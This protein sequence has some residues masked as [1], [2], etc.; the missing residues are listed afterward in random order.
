MV[1]DPTTSIANSSDPGKS[2]D[3]FRSAFGFD[4]SSESRWLEIA[5]AAMNDTPSLGR[6]GRY[7]LLA[8]AGRGGQGIVY[9]ARQPGTNRTIAIKRL[10]AGVH[11]SDAS[12]ARFHRE[13]SLVASLDHPGIV[14]VLGM[15]EVP[16]EL[17]SHELLLMEWVDGAAIDQWADALP[18]DRWQDILP[19]FVQVCDAIAFAHQRGVMHRDLKPSNILVD[20]TGRARVLDFGLAR[21]TGPSLTISRTTGF[22]GTPAYAS[23]EAIGVSAS[24]LTGDAARTGA[25]ALQG[26]DTRSDIFSLGAVLYRL[27]TRREPFDSNRG[28]GPLFDAIRSTDPVSPRSIVADLPRELEAI[29]LKALRK[30]PSERYQS[31][32]AFATDLRRFLA[33]ET[34]VAIPPSFGYQLR[35]VVRRHRAASMIAC[36]GLVGVL[37]FAGTATW[38]AIKLGK[39]RNALAAAQVQIKEKTTQ[40]EAALRDALVKSQQQQSTSAFLTSVLGEVD[41]LREHD[42]AVT[43]KELLDR[44]AQRLYAG[45]LADQPAEEIRLLLTIAEAMRGIAQ[46]NS[47]IKLADEALARAVRHFG[48]RS[49]L[50]AKAHHH[51]GILHES[52][53]N[54]I[55]SLSHYFTCEELYREIYGPNSPNT[56]TAIHNVGVGLRGAGYARDSL[57]YYCT[58]WEHRSAIFGELSDESI[59]SERGVSIAYRS[60]S[61]QATYKALTMDALVRAKQQNSFHRIFL[62]HNLADTFDQNTESDQVL[63]LRQWS[64]D[65]CRA[66]N[67]V[68]SDQLMRSLQVV[69]RSHLARQQP[70]LA[71]PLLLECVQTSESVFGH[72]HWNTIRARTEYA[73]ALCSAGHR[74]E[75]LS[76]LFEQYD[77]CS[78]VES[79]NNTIRTEV[80]GA[81]ADE[82]RNAGDLDTALSFREEHAESYDFFMAPSAGV[83]SRWERFANAAADAGNQAK[84]E[85]ALTRAIPSEQAARNRPSKLVDLSLALSDA[86]KQQGDSIGAQEAF[87]QATTFAGSDKKLAKRVADSLSK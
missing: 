55:A 75:G 83:V 72:D 62:A 48:E 60:M 73:R 46:Y 77:A 12:R 51:L 68:D 2:R 36:G 86:R 52:N 4:D 78:R 65:E 17:G 39:E 31:M 24:A 32:D 1:D 49:E 59:S 44:A 45:E 15:E 74:D 67:P 47:G 80:P 5:H 21:P 71:L 66:Q 25:G 54:P 30:S 79:P 87:A 22:V 43:L 18:P 34:V 56:V 53:R 7:E 27:I 84:R 3:A 76:I 81:L 26:I 69:A 29:V 9:K 38:L 41:N 23:P 13:V 37:L 58:T 70:E 14:S 82:L 20:A 6:L 33:G 28:I 19:V 40:I 64:L 8:E 57:E 85:Y 35:S 50:A 42:R 10:A 63:Q 11:A 16:G 61:D